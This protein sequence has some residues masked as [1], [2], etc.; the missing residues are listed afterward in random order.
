MPRLSPTLLA[1]LL[2][3]ALAGCNEDPVSPEEAL[4]GSYTLSTVNG[5][6][7]PATIFEAGT[8][9]VEITAGE[10]QVG[11]DNTFD[12][13]VTV[14]STDNDVS[15]TVTNQHSG[16]WTITGNV[17]SFT[18]SANGFTDTGVLDG[19]QLTVVFQGR[20]L[21]FRKDG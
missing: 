10:L 2:P 18:Y 21:V 13:S 17:V 4:P 20:A 5:S 15:Q 19:D 11:A 12:L 1:F 6:A 16:S 9:M 8:Q 14:R 3:L 7:L